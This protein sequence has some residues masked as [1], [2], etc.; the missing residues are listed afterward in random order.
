MRLRCTVVLLVR[1]RRRRR[2]VL[3]RSRGWRRTARWLWIWLPRRRWRRRNWT[4]PLICRG[5]RR[6]RLI[7]TWCSRIETTLLGHPRARA[8]SYAWLARVCPIKL[9]PRRSIAL[10]SLKPGLEV[11]GGLRSWWRTRR[12]PPML[13]PHALP[14]SE[15]ICLALRIV[16]VVARLLG[17]RRGLWKIGK[18]AG[19]LRRGGLFRFRRRL[20]ALR[21]GTTW[22][23][24]KVG[25]CLVR[26]GTW[27]R[28]RGA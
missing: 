4:T 13:L 23:R 6:R 11:V 26:V 27:R 3:V 15:D 19:T 2:T 18:A 22:R 9:F 8:T 1:S 16:L 28:V 24:G 5:T 12:G 7:S 20:S 17:G 10:G 14:R 21:T 25:V